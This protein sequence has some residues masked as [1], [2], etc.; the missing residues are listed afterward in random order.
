[1]PRVPRPART[2]KAGGE[3][4]GASGSRPA[5]PA[6]ML[7]A[8]KLAQEKG[9][10]VPDEAKAGLA[11]MSKWID[12]NQVKNRGERRRQPVNALTR[13]SAHSGQDV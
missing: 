6:Q 3:I 4:A 13:G 11:A 9:I 2:K 1:M 5:S 12:S 8:E 10:V 7:F